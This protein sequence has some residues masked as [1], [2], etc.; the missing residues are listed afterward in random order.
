MRRMS[1]TPDGERDVSVKVSAGED[2][3]VTGVPSFIRLLCA[4]DEQ[5]RVLRGPGALEPDPARVTPKL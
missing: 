5:S 3:D 1:L 4:G 2:G